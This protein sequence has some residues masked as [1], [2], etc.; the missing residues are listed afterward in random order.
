MDWNNLW[1]VGGA[2]FALISIFLVTVIVIKWNADSIKKKGVDYGTL[3]F[4]ILFFP[5]GSIY[6]FYI[7]RFDLSLEPSLDVWEKSASY[8]NNILNPILLLTTIILLYR[9]WRTSDTEFSKM[10]S[11]TASSQI[12]ERLDKICE[13]AINNL[14]AE[15][16]F[17]VDGEV[18]VMEECRAGHESGLKSFVETPLG[19]DYKNVAHFKSNF[20]DISIKLRENNPK[21]LNTILS[22]SVQTQGFDKG[23]GYNNASSF[24]D[25]DN[26]LKNHLRKNALFSSK[27]NRY[28]YTLI[29]SIAAHCQELT[30]IDKKNNNETSYTRAG[31]RAV[32]LAFGDKLL[33]FL[34]CYFEKS[35]RN[36]PICNSESEKLISHHLEKLVRDLII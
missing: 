10:Y 17:F 27:R 7:S 32:R 34:Y 16:L 36:K 18:L 28:F 31:Y 8:F 35:I 19:S 30:E 12:L 24:E 14:K 21:M 26:G 4:S 29:E 11:V 22:Y 3:L 20:D 6:L 2:I 25:I 13:K 15:S 1:F 23:A 5:I 9:T 33:M